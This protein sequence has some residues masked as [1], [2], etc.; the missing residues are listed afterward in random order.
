MSI[1]TTQGKP[2]V[3]DS[4]QP[5]RGLVAT[6]VEKNSAGNSKDGEGLFAAKGTGKIPS[7]NTKVIELPEKTAP[8]PASKT[9][10][11]CKKMGRVFRR[12]RV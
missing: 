2:K 6:R 4:A 1:N 11:C 7:P 3:A 12:R 8:R 5:E 10:G 9:L